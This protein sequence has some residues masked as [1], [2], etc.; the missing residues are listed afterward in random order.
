MAETKET[1]KIHGTISKL[2]GHTRKSLARILGL[3]KR[4][5][6]NEKKITLIKKK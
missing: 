6:N 3:E 2:A 1:K 4:V 5:G